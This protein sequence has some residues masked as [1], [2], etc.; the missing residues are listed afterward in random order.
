MVDTPGTF[1]AMVLSI[2]LYLRLG[3]GM[4]H[5]GVRWKL[6]T[7]AQTSDIGLIICTPV[8]PLPMTATRLP[9]RSRL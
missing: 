6:T 3:T 2:S 5:C 9:L 4:I 1:E 8:E 7:L